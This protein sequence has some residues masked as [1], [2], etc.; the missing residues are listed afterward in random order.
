MISYIT[1]TFQ[2]WGVKSDGEHFCQGLIELLVELEKNAT[3][4]AH[5]I[6]PSVLG[7]AFRCTLTTQM[8]A[9]RLG[10]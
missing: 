8:I 3:G 10:Q 6:M 9:R 4:K 5:T 7:V 1:T 2:Y